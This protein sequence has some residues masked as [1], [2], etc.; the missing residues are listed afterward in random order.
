VLATIPSATLLGVE[1]HP[2]SVEVDVA[3]GL[4]SFN[5][6]GLPDAACRESRDRVRAALGSSGVAWPM[7]RVTV[8]LAPSGLRK[9][10]PG[11]D[12]P[13]AVGLLVA[14]GELR[15]SQVAGCAFI[16]EL[17]LDGSVRHVAGMVP[18]VDAIAE[19]AVVVPE[20]S[21]SEAVLVGRHVV[22][23]VTGLQQLVAC[24]RGHERWPRLPATPVPVPDP[25]PDLADVRGQRVG[26][27]AVE[28]AA[29][30]GHHLLLV[31][32][33]GAGKTMLA[34]RLPGLLPALDRVQA[35]ETTRIHSAAAL[36]LP[37]WGL[38]E[39]PPFRAPH[40]SASLVSVVGG[41]SALM[42]PGEISLA[43]NGVLLLDELGEF[44]TVVLD[45]LRQPLEEG[46]V[47]LSRARATV[48]FP[49]RFLLVGAMN[50]C[51]CGEGGPPGSCRCSETDRARYG[52]RLS[53]PMLD[54]FDLRVA[55]S[56]PDVDELLGG[57]PAEGSATAADRVRVA[58][59]LAARR[60]M[61]CNAEIPSRWLEKVAPLTAGAAKVVEY[62]L[63]QGALS[64]RGLDRVKRVARTLADLEGVDGPLNESFV[65]GALELRA[66]PSWLE[67][68]S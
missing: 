59:A 44:P 62:R 15:P 2:V 9:G 14:T 29:A 16:G 19:A 51:P 17:G 52:R 11:L 30:G 26:R 28:V 24:L 38:I 18:Q 42:R 64:A 6:V 67:T 7:R 31:G 4:P 20:A 1:G 66:E 61:R 63:R 13:I 57:R 49:A 50:P 45:A 54:R 53:G 68:V 36:P 41:G 39:R 21:A 3:S 40:H 48:T 43:T 27:W 32:P 65:C 47:R 46:V 35:L 12:L 5:V 25:P 34:R 8:N 33:P 23:T 56:R 58:R 10:G 37:P 22:R 60:G 55:L